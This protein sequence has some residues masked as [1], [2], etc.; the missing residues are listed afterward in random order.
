MTSGRQFREYHH[1]ADEI[2]A[3]RK[4]VKRAP[5]GIQNMSHGQPLRLEAIAKTVFRSFG[6]EKLLKLGALPEPVTENY[7]K[8]PNC[9]KFLDPNQFRNTL[10][11]IAKY[12]RDSI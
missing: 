12:L 5:P 8:T 7:N 9:N 3:I 1:L 6:K 2:R 11:A 4:L 10:P